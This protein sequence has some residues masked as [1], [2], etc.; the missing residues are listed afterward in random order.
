MKEESG[1]DEGSPRSSPMRIASVAIGAALIAILLVIVLSV[2][3]H[4]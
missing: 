3:S 4:L 2:A 1:T